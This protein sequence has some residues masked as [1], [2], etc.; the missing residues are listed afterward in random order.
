MKRIFRAISIALLTC[1]LIS[2]CGR[3]PK[4]VAEYKEWYE[5][6]QIEN[7][8]GFKYLGSSHTNNRYSI[9]IECDEENLGAF[10]DVIKR[11]NEF[12]KKNADYFPEDAQI[13]IL[14]SYG[15]PNPAAVFDCYNRPGDYFGEISGQGIE[16][17]LEVKYMSVNVFDLKIAYDKHQNEFSIP[18]LVLTVENPE[19]VN[20][21]DLEFL[22]GFTNLRQI[23]IY[24][25]ALGYDMAPTLE[26]INKYAPGVEV[27]QVVDG[28]ELQKWQ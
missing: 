2:G 11:H 12:V 9:S 19:S 17:N 24:Y 13:Y 6:L 22:K 23:I 14:S 28:G 3:I 27:Y 10:N 25:N 16:E 8:D 15:G 26:G 20:S 1:V 21:D 5:A 18:V 4:E 7:R